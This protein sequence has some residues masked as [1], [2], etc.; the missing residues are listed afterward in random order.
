MKKILDDLMVTNKGW[1]M[2]REEYEYICSFLGGKNFLVFGTGNDT[3]L[4][5]TANENGFNVFLEDQSQ[6]INKT[7]TDVFEV[8]YSTYRSEHKRLLEE[9]KKEKFKNLKMS[10]PKIV[11]ETNWDCIF[12]DAPV[13]KNDLSPGRMQSIFMAKILSNKNTDIFV[14]DCDRTVEDTYTKEMFKVFVKQLKKLRHVK[15]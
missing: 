11:M 15:I 6:W 3:P 7:D 14:H 2:E 10:L 4:W 12:V 8:K 1:Q 13:G 9:Y 5:R